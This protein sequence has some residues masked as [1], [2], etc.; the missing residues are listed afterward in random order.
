MAIQAILFDIDGT[1]VDSNYLHIEA[2]SRALTEA[3]AKVDSWRVHRAIGM[4]SEK[5]LA[6]LLGNDAETL[7]PR[8]AELHGNYYGELSGRLRAFDGAREL[9]RTLAD[10][11]LTVV[12]ATSAPEKE[13]AELRK[14]LN[15]EESITVVTS[16]ND[17]STAKPAPDVVEVALREADVPASEAIMVGDTVWDVEAA[18]RAG[19]ACVGVETGGISPAE[20]LDA[21]AVATYRDVLSLLSALDESPLVH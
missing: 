17:V 9:V 6:E 8:A 18:A 7:G 11:G 16:A 21:G 1:L 3:G 20:L 12:L 5:L 13:L 15:I 4:D 2:W 10:R 14:V 19:V